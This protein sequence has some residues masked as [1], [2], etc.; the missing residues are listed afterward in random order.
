MRTRRAKK[1]VVLLSD[2]EAR[3]LFNMAREELREEPMQ[4]R[5]LLIEEARRRGLI[6]EK[7]NGEGEK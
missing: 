4:M 1:I 7:S 5:H 3:V 2:A 6:R